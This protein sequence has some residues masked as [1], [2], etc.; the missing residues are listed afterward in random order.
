[1]HPSLLA[2][3]C[4]PLSPHSQTCPSVGLTRP[5]MMP[6]SNF[7]GSGSAAPCHTPLTCSGSTA[8]NA[9]LPYDVCS[10]CPESGPQFL[11][12]HTWLPLELSHWY[13]T[14]QIGGSS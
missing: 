11:P 3:V 7:S 10:M 4:Q 14:Q 12:A 1:M 2:L 13:G 9:H 6:L 5:R 8:S